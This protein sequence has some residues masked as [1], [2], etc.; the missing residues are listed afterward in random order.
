MANKLISELPEQTIPAAATDLL[1]LETAGGTSYHTTVAN[2]FRAP[3]ATVATLPA[4]DGSNPGRVYF[5]SD[6]LKVGETAGGGT[7]TLVYDDGVAWRRVGDDT[8]AS[9]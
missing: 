8:T 5:A 4:N 7:G 6:A 1:E 3:N 9:A 2:L